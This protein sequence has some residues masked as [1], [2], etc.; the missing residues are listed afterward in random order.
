M[1]KN[2]DFYERRTNAFGNSGGS[3][4]SL[5]KISAAFSDP[6]IKSDKRF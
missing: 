4:K 3:N 6:L 1:S 5:I 2:K